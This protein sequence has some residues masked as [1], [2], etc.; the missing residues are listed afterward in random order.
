MDGIVDLINDERHL[1]LGD[2]FIKFDADRL[3]FVVC[4]NTTSG[5]INVRRFTNLGGAVN[6]ARR[7]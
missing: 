4:L 7:V 5:A 1:S 3:L 6:C 2:R